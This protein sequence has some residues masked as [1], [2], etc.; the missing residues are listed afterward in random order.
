MDLSGA[1]A[2]ALAERFLGDLG[3]RHVVFDDAG[4]GE[5]AALQLAREGWERS[6]TVVYGVHR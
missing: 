5:R 4:A 3:H 6:R 1:E 2:A